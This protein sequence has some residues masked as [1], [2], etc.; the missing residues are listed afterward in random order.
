MSKEK[1]LKKAMNLI[2]GVEGLGTGFKDINGRVVQANGLIRHK[3]YIGI[4]EEGTVIW[5]YNHV[6]YSTTHAAFG[7]SINNTFVP[8]YMLKDVE[9]IE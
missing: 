8:L 1:K 7:V 4:C 9:V 6:M 5:Y 2:Y 3:R